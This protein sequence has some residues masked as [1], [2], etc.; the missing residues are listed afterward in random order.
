M[1]SVSIFGTGNMANAIGGVFADGGSSVA[2]IIADA[3]GAARIEG[4]IVVLAVPYP[5]VGQHPRGVRRPVRRQDRRRHH[6]PGRL[7]RRSTRSPFPSGSSAAARDPGQAA[8]SDASSRRSTRPS[9][10]R[11]RP[12]SRSANCPRP[13]SS[14]ATTR[15]RS[16]P[17]R[18]P[19]RP[20]ESRRSTP[21][22]S[23]V[24]TSSRRSASCSSPSPR[25]ADR[26]DRRIRRSAPGWVPDTLS[27]Y[28]G[29]GASHG[30][31]QPRHDDGCRH[32]AGRRPR[33]DVLVLRRGPRARAAR[34][35]RAR[36][37]GASGARSGALRWCA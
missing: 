20:A 31:D 19:S 23:P 11:S 13:S 33:D 3:T 2:Y 21:D 16:P 18:Q 22:R 37:R 8:R 24:R 7:R 9:R 32:P 36:T 26:L 4:E 14:P 29:R 1:T 25:R 12:A 15:P 30:P 5:A 28:H 35:A 6:Q 34:G 27:R 17:S 10:A